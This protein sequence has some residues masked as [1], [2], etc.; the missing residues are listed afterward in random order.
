MKT[1][2]IALEPHDD[3]ISLRDK[4]SWAKTERIL[5]VVPRGTALRART[6]DLQMLKRHADS[7]GAA[8]GM[9][10]RSEE[11]R[12]IAREM[13]IPVFKRLP[14]AMR[15]AWPD[16]PVKHGPTRRHE[17]PDLSEM[18]REAFPA[19]AAW[20]DR[21]GIRLA[22]FS[23]G[24]L[25]ILAVLVVFLPTATIQISPATRTQSLDF[26]TN[27]SLAYSGIN[28]Q[29]NLP[30]RQASLI[31]EETR[32]KASTGSTPFPDKRATGTV[33]FR[34]LTTSVLS[35]PLGTV[36]SS[37]DEPP[38]RFETTEAAEVAAGF[39]KTADVPVQAVE[40]GSA[41]NLSADTLVAMQADLG[42]NLTVTNPG[43]TSGGTDRMTAIPTTADRKV[44]RAML[45]DDLLTEC[46][47]SIERTL[48]SGDVLFPGAMAVSEVLTESY[49]PAEGQAGD[50]L[51]LT[52]K[53]Q[54]QGQYAAA[55]DIS[56]LAEMILGVGLPE[57]Y[58]PVPGGLVVEAVSLPVTSADGI[59]QWNVH[60]EALLAA[61]VDPQT[62]VQLSQGHR[63]DT[64]ARR[65]TGS[66]PL[67][68][69]PE[70]TL[71]P[72]WWPWLPLVPFNITVVTSG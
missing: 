43:P 53:L 46:R 12:L 49:F 70:I 50:T 44:L 30:A 39:G 51:T 18:R 45:V 68:G 64:A 60:A 26:T 57:G 47:S 36:V 2:V 11:M 23:L 34:N 3:V 63:L 31:V 62:V 22:F 19:E 38:I 6:L 25:A 42:T 16:G 29:G 52:L 9:V 15:A 14:N 35:I 4:M 67:N 72:G 10:T 17:P 59:T 13:G 21:Y 24:V 20:R 54:C 66:L 56:S 55:A 65:L 37:Q 27:A 48:S 5:L 58:T 32:S 8:L 41:G 28:L 1:Q 69:T 71:K 61:Q 7:V 40:P 33:E